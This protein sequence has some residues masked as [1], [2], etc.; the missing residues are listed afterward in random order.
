MRSLSHERELEIETDYKLKHRRIP[1]KI[2]LHPT[3]IVDLCPIC[4]G[5][6]KKIAATTNAKICQNCK[7]ILYPD[8][9]FAAKFQTGSELKK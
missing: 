7:Y 9:V 2:G 1:P 5:V 6:M 3:Q 4:E 8:N